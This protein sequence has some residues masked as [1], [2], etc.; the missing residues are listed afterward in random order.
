MSLK[1][2]NLNNNLQVEESGS[3][4]D[5]AIKEEHNNVN[6]ITTGSSFKSNNIAIHHNNVSTL[7]VYIII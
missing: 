6:K 3:V 4:L 2:P 1:L 7:S 5:N